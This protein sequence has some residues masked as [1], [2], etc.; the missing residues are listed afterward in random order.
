M[1]H[2]GGRKPRVAILVLAL[3]AVALAF[4]LFSIFRQLR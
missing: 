3:S 4:Y 1:T 2:D